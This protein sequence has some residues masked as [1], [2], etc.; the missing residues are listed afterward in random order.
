M[1]QINLPIQA[2]AGWAIP[3]CLCMSSCQ[4]P[5]SSGRS[6]QALHPNIVIILA[7]DLSW[8]DIGCYG[9]VNN[10]TP[11]IDQ[12][13]SEGLRFTRA[14]S[15]ATMC[16]PTRQALYTGMYPI[17]NGGYANHSHVRDDIRSLPHYLVELGYRV[18]LTGKGHVRPPERFP[19]EKI[20][21]FPANQGEQRRGIDPEKKYE[22][23]NEFIARSGDEA[24][25]LVVASTNPHSPWD[26]GDPSLYQ[27]E[28]LSLPPHWIDTPMFREAYADYLAE[29]TLL[30]EEVGNIMELLKE[31]QVY[32]N[33]LILFLS[34]QG[35]GFPGDK[36]TVWNPGIHVGMI[37]VWAGRIV[38]GSIT[39]A[40]VQYEDILPTMIDLAGGQ[41]PAD[42][43]GMSMKELLTGKLNE[44]RQYAFSL[45]HN[46]PEG[47][48]YPIRMVTD[49][50]Y[51]L[52]W[53][54]LYDEEYILIHIENKEWFMSWK[55]VKTD[56]AK[57][58]MNR[59][60]NRPE[61]EFYDIEY[62]PF[63]LVNLYH[64]EHH[65]DKIDELKQAMAEW[66]ASQGDL[67]A[68]MDDIN[69]PGIPPEKVP[70][71]REAL[72]QLNLVNDGPGL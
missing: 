35:S 64:Q 66:M 70:Q 47:P 16:A 8:F 3:F 72:K 31:N 32:D 39:D 20:P 60:K 53:N 29:V 63:E 49:G 11:N 61:Y 50:K 2:F 28:T 43:D 59:Y 58:L 68:E 14:F 62:D 57:F 37:A 1:N 24:F 69:N 40:L 15:S 46:I 30:D 54:I 71:M 6:G 17:K 56:Q 26:N 38:A 5:G 51:K 34:E 42:L 27:P 55:E 21:G 65:L 4:G 13:A 41:I 45:H 18:G 33:T 12:L 36:W 23:V 7:D 19:F 22:S 48:A 67:G 9:A 44:H 52:I 10:R 25:C